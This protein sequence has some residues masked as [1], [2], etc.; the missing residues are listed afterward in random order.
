MQDELTRAQHY[1]LLAQQLRET[2]QDEPDP[3]RRK[4]LLDLS[5]Q[6]DNLADK[7]GAKHRSRESA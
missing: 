1:R 4:E 3:A 5:V 7:L 2:A 6:Y